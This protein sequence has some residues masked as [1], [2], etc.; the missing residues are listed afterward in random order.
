MR[1]C[2]ERVVDGLDRGDCRRVDVGQ[3]GPSCGDLHRVHDVPTRDQC[4]ERADVVAVLEP[5]FEQDVTVEAFRHGALVVDD[6]HRRVD[7]RRVAL[8]EDEQRVDFGRR[9]E[10]PLSLDVVVEPEDRGRCP[11]VED[12]S[13]RVE[14]VGER[15]ERVGGATLVAGVGRSRSR[16][17]VMTPSVPSLPTNSWVRSGPTA[18]RGAPP[19]LIARPSARTT[20]RPT[21]MSSIFP[22]RVEYWPAPRQA[23]HPPTVE[24]STDC[25]QCPTVTP[26]SARSSASSTSPNVPARTSRIIDAASTSTTPASPQQSSTTPPCSGTLAPHTPLRPA[27]GVTW[28]AAPRRRCEAPP[29]PRRLWTGARRPKPAPRPGCRGPRSSRAATSRG[30]SRPARRRRA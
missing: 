22:Y 9:L 20:S 25:G 19:V 12:A 28:N 4:L 27:A 16:A 21:T 14:P 1:R 30:W 11:A 10:V 18:A 2:D 8:V 15:A 26:W 13:T 29:L 5:A 3:R 24:S 23:S 17:L 6:G 7:Q